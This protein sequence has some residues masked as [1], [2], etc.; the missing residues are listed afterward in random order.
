[1]RRLLV[2]AALWC[3]ALCGAGDVRIDFES[4][5]DYADHFRRLS[6]TGTALQTDPAAGEPDNDTVQT[7]SGGLVIA[8]D[9]TPADG[10]STRSLFAAPLSV[11]ADV[12]YGTASNSFGVYFIH[13]VDPADAYLALFNVDNAGAGDLF[14]FSSNGNPQTASAG[15]LIQA[16]AVESGVTT[17]GRLNRIEI[18]FAANA[19]GEPVLSLWTGT[20]CASLVLTGLAARASAEVG[21]RFSP[22]S[23]ND[24]EFDNVAIRPVPPVW[25]P[26][27]ETSGA[28]FLHRLAAGEPQKVV[29]YGTSL[30]AGGPWVGQMQDWLTNTYAGTLTLI[31]SGLSGKNS[32]NGLESLDSKVLA[33]RPDTV[34]IEF[35]MNDAF[36]AYAHPN[37]NISV[38]QAHSNLLL[39]I[40]RIF[41]NRADTEIILQTMNPAWDSPGGSG[42]SATVRASL[43][44]CYQTYRDVATARGV[45]LVD[46]YPNWK[47]LQLTNPALF[48]AYVPDGVHPV[49]AGTAAVTLPLLKERLVGEVRMVDTNRPGPARVDADICVYGGS[50]AGVA[51]AVQVARRGK[52]CVLVSPERRFGGLTSGGLG[53]T[54][55]GSDKNII[56]GI[57]REFYRRVYLHYADS[58]AWTRETR[59]Q[60]I[61]RSSMDPD[62]TLRVMFTFEPKVAARILEEMLAEARVTVAP[63]R[64]RRGGGGV[65]LD[66]ARIREIVTDDGA[67]IVRA[68]MF[69]DATYEGDL[70]AEA[71]VPYVVGREANAV[72]GETL[73][74]IQTARATGNQLPGGIDPYVVPGQPASGLLPGVEADA[75]GADGTGDGRLQ[76]Y[77]Y[78]LCLT[79]V[80]SNRLPIAQPAGYREED[81]EILFRS[82]E[83]GQSDRFFKRSP[84]P[85]RKT[86]S[87][88][89]SGASMDF[90]GGNY[91]VTGGWN[92]AEAGYAQ[93][94]AIRQAHEYYQRGFIWTLQN[95]ARVPS[96]IRSAWAAWGLPLD[97]FGETGG[98]PHQLYI[99]EARRMAG[100]YVITE[101]HVDQES[102]FVAD[103]PVGMGVYN[104]DS[105]H[106][107]RHVN[108]GGYVR[109]EGDVQVAPAHGAYGV[110]YRA[111]VPPT[112]SVRNLL[113][114]VCLSATHIAYGSIRMEPVFM[115]LAQSAAAAAVQALD[116]GVPVQQVDYER[117]RLHLAAAG[118]VVSKTAPP[119]GT[120]LILDNANAT[121]VAVIGAWT[122]SDATTG[123]YGTNYLHDGNVG[124]GTKSVTFTP[125]FA[126]EG[127]YSV[128]VRWTEHINRATNVPVDIA[129]TAGTTTVTV[130]QQANGGVWNHLLTTNFAAG[131]SGS[132]T[133]RTTDTSGFVIADAV[134]FST[135]I[136]T[137]RIVADD[138]T[139]AESGA[140]TARLLVVREGSID[141]PLTVRY[142]AAGV[143]TA[144]TDYE[145]LDG[146]VVLPAGAST[147]A[148]VVRPLRD[149]AAEGD[150]AVVFALVADPAYAIG[151]P[152]SATVTIRDRAIDAWRH[153]RFT[154][155]QLADAD[156]S[157]ENADPDVDG[158]PNTLEHAFGSNPLLADAGL[159][160]PAAGW[161]SD[162]GDRWFMLE[163]FRDSAALRYGV[164]WTSSLL[165]AA[166]SPAGVS[167]EFYLPAS[168]RFARAVRVTPEDAR[169]FLRLEVR[170]EW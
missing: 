68:G 44:D 34:I 14:R 40:D 152:A 87:N 149:A 55:V 135:G 98:W 3:P 118:Q 104:M 106:V 29:V 10:A 154:P 95:H 33:H 48:Q 56:G 158:L 20:S 115:V 42:T 129:H 61:A 141:L 140:D 74:G 124:K 116:D 31:N 89:D 143:A 27:P 136:P 16:A 170:E 32:K 76:A 78:R 121:G 96:A 63:G 51:A 150:E 162:G 15:A 2:C 147:A 123:F 26:P 54:D 70:M 122:S 110:S 169:L 64:L 71:G 21:L 101:H 131:S 77:C 99:R 52:S 92:Y 127:A 139:A 47:T 8:Y 148:L 9:A 100:D 157:G 109:N 6:G 159:F 35:G 163:Y 102:G 168:G 80:A 59:A 146:T 66:G 120:D 107:Q 7:S 69:I 73:N 1:M 91:S 138:A 155:E 60:Y 160:C 166:W 12:R 114:P 5:G 133:I 151:S 13:P 83:A 164:E 75:G 22:R 134:R 119:S 72:H 130:N 90:I 58:N 81:F 144:G 79:D 84:M 132:V 18:G 117:L 105:H 88:N 112:N 38:T 113:V 82:I 19:Q 108:A 145:A 161:R 45:L 39:M 103:D 49:A 24:I 85:N 97:E 94:E 67:A 93:R 62:D 142:A 57:A 165:P 153:V 53:W 50:A 128:Y 156:I 41:T 43:P 46:H 167:E 137:V 126:E 11:A 25:A 4:A 23:A 111:I 30:T 37:Y 28:R 125:T 36:T 17:D 65:T 86:D